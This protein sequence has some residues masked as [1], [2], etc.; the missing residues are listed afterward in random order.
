ML[1]IGMGAHLQGFPAGWGFSGGKT[2]RWRQVGN[3][4][5]PPAAK[6]VGIAIR[7]ALTTRQNFYAACL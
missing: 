2:S 5:P 4:F 6:A 7:T 1:T 3:A